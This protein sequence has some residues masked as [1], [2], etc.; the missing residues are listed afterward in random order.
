[1][2][3]PGFRPP[4][5]EARH[6][7]PVAAILAAVATLLLLLVIY[8]SRNLTLARERLEDSLLQ[9]SV[10]VIRAIEAGNRAGMR[11]RWAAGQMQT[12]VEEIGRS[13]KIDFISVIGADGKILAHTQPEMVGQSAEIDRSQYETPSSSLLT[14]NYHNAEDVHIFEIIRTV[15]PQ[16]MP[17]NVS[18]HG[19]HSAHEE[20]GVAH[21]GPGRGMGKMRGMMA[22]TADIPQIA[23]IRLGMKMTELHTIRERD[24]RNAILMFLVLAVIGS[25]ALYV[26]VLMQNYYAVNHAYQTIQSYAQH[27]VDSMANGLIS[28]DTAG[29]IVTMNRQAH[30]ILGIAPDVL[31]QDV[32][33]AQVLPLHRCDVL[34]ELEDGTA[35]IER[36]VS[37]STA[38]RTVLPLSLS[39]STLTD[40]AGEHL[41]TVLLFRDLSDVKALQEQVKRSERLASLG[42]L[43]AGV[44]HEIRNPLGAL[45]GFLQY[46]HRKAEIK[47]QD[48]TYLAV[49]VQEVDRLNAVISNLLDFARPKAPKMAPCDVADLLRHV[50][51]LIE[52]DAQA[53]A[54]E[55]TLDIDDALPPVS[56]DRDQI[57]QVL[58]NLL[59]NA[60]HATDAG[61]RI[62][63]SAAQQPDARRLGITI[64]D[65]GQGISPDVLP[66]IFD[67]FFSTKKQGTGLG[68]A[69]A[70]M[71]VEQHHGELSAESVVGQGTTFHIH[72]PAGAN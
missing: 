9:E 17:G 39:A 44:A 47:E 26:I 30:Q 6:Y 14:R 10:T 19:D 51:T 18:G 35:V 22:D 41:G 53:K 36:E 8:T 4:R 65:T 69:I 66:K 29:K 20:E 67:P 46:F 54:L 23:M 13:E 11:M 40:D 33:L 57:T 62:W 58:L 34:Q 48:K 5:Y 16:E 3:F 12:L 49:M 7:M 63:L 42:Q 64:A 31:V 38:T 50:V 43:A 68:L 56:L 60:I 55:L 59:L 61:G 28:L 25:A 45:K 72:L 71:I 21:S 70:Y 1:M 2:K 37:C 24:L 15:P 52:G 27:V 32:P